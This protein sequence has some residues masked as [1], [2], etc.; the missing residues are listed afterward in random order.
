MGISAVTLQGWFKDTLRIER[1]FEKRGK[2]AIFVATAGGGEE[3][4]F[5][6]DE[7]LSS[8]SN[9]ELEKVLAIRKKINSPF[10]ASIAQY[11]FLSNGSFFWSYDLG[12][13]SSFQNLFDEWPQNP[14]RLMRLISHAVEAI[15]AIHEVGY[16][17]GDLRTGN[18]WLK[19][20][21]DGAENLLVVGENIAAWSSRLT[22]DNSD[23]SVD[24]AYCTAPE[25]AAGEQIGAAADIYAL[26]VLLYRAVIGKWPFEGNNA[27]EITAAHAT[28]PL[29]KPQTHPPIHD[30]LWDTISQSLQKKPSDRGSIQEFAKALQPFA[31][32]QK[33]M[34][35][36]MSEDKEIAEPSPQPTNAHPTNSI[37][38][39]TSKSREQTLS[40]FDF[41]PVPKR[42]IT[43]SDSLPQNHSIIQFSEASPVRPSQ[44]DEEAVPESESP[45]NEQVLV[46]VDETASDFSSTGLLSADEQVSEDVT[47]PV[48]VAPLQVLVGARP[49]P[50]SSAFEE[51][52][53]DKIE[54]TEKGLPVALVM[55]EPT[56]SQSIDV[57]EVP[58][59][60]TDKGSSPAPESESRKKGVETYQ[61]VLFVVLSAI[62]TLLLLKIVDKII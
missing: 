41:I 22:L 24:S 55:E 1:L 8:Q 47:E 13:S 9:R 14:L 10:L 28:E 54:P 20:R 60:K 31:D 30:D 40:S 42:L 36:K 51:E 43:P 48:H 35:L 3:L 37:F 7:K 16:F 53:T 19:L 17:H 59:A 34:F 27:W 26:G 23:M 56:V 58:L 45:E 46:A 61:F 32:Y 29:S 6:L 57:T 50:A 11:S 5:V 2:I 39:G 62:I 33:P 49:M 4:L 52:R 38:K 15:R 25:I 44:Q 18:L 21:E 12:A